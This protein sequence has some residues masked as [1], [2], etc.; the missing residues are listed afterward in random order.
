MYFTDLKQSLE[1][2]ATAMPKCLEAENNYLPSNFSHWEN[3]H[4]SGRWI[5]AVLMLENCIGFEIPKKLERAMLF[6]FK[7]LMSNPYG[8]LINDRDLF[9]NKDDVRLH[10]H[11]IREAFMALYTL[12][13]YR[14]SKWA[15]GCG[16]KLIDTIDRR[17]FENTLTDNEIRSVLGIEIPDV[18]ETDPNEPVDPFSNDDETRSTGRAIEALL[19]F[20]KATGSE[21]ALI[22]L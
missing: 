4:D 11:S 19:Q 14:N 15:V 5:E 16:E 18:I 10:Y 1:A 7:A 13:K 22:V 20:Y 8:L 9:E 6:N 3:A 12:V 2:V 17:F 21:K